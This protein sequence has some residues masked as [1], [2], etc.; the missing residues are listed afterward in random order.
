MIPGAMSKTTGRLALSLVILFTPAPA[1]AD[2]VDD[3]RA[4]LAALRADYDRRIESL[5]K[6]LTDLT[7]A[8]DHAAATAAESKAIAEQAKENADEAKNVANETKRKLAEY[9]TTPYFDTLEGGVA[10][11]FEFH[12]YLRSGFGLNERGEAQADFRIPYSLGHYRLGNEPGTYGEFAFVQN[13]INPDRSS[14]KAWFKTEVMV[15]AETLNIQSYDPS[16][17]FRLREAFGQAGNILEGRW[18]PTKFWAGDRYYQR[19]DIYVLDYFIRDMSGYGGGIESLPIGSATVDIAYIGALEPS[20][21]YAYFNAAKSTIDIRA[22][23]IKVP[24]GRAAFWYDYAFAKQEQVIDNVTIP[25]AGGNAIGFEHRRDE[26]LGGYH[27][28][29]FQ[30]AGG[31][32]S[33]LSPSL[34]PPTPYWRDSRR[35]TI[36]DSAVLQ[37]NERFAIQP[38]GGVTWYKRGNPGESYYRWL[39]F[40]A[41]PVYYFNKYFSFATEIGIENV[42]APTGQNGWLRKL[43]FAPQISPKPEFFSRPVLRAFLTLANWSP[44][45]QGIVGGP[46]YANRTTGLSAGLQVESWW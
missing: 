33:N 13:W 44:T 3:L 30:A 12:G 16:S 45:L 25:S 1:L 46:A 27:L 17:I 14:D 18:R 43:S 31:A 19:Q 4:E 40:G 10:R 23:K 6:R 39:T 35:Y 21:D 8:H 36:T 9:A 20:A 15:S 29:T 32:A 37:W 28:F 41:R 22:A 34:Q 5:E 26:F 42:A 11:G 7:A 2:E 24:G 38:V